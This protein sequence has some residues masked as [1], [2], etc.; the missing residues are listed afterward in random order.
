MSLTFAQAEVSK[1]GGSLRQQRTPKLSLAMEELPD[2]EHGPAWS[3][4]RA[5]RT[6]AI[7]TARL[8]ATPVDV[9]GVA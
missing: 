2:G 8:R 6:V 3:R 7:V 5:R 9:A 1:E 4:F